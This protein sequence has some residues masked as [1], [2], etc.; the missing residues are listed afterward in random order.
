M[1]RTRRIVKPPKY[2][3]IKRLALSLPG[4]IE[5][6]DRH[7]QWFNIGKK[8]FALF[9]AKSGR[10]ILRLPHGQ[11][12]MLIEARP[13]SFAPMR[14]GAMLW[15]YTDVDALDA[16]EL[17]DY[18]TAAWRHTAPKKI[19]RSFEEAARPR[20]AQPLRVRRTQTSA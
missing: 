12:M 15:L 7:G 3:A 17:R 2:A 16:S 1:T 9:W 18:V 20:R 13:D 19:V 14:S 5:L 10:W 4:A 11:I 8:T 6:S